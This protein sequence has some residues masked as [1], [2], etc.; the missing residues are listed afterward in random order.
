MAGKERSFLS[1]LRQDSRRAPGS[2]TEDLIDLP[3]LSEDNAV[4]CLKARFEDKSGSQIYTYLGEQVRFDARCVRCPPALRQ[5][6]ACV[7]R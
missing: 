5:A 1:R 6:L 3:E 2:H 4:Q 7:H